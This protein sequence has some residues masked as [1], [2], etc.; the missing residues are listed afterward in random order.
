[1]RGQPRCRPGGVAE[2]A[3]PLGHR[4]RQAKLA[5][6][7]SKLPDAAG[8]ARRRTG[9]G[10]AHDGA[11]ARTQF[12][13]V[14]RIRQGPQA[15]RGA[16]TASIPAIRR[17]P[18][19][20]E[21]SPIPSAVTPKPNATFR[22]RSGSDPRNAEVL[23]RSGLLLLPAGTAL[24]GRKRSGQGHAAGAANKRYRN[25]L[26][27]VLGHLGR[28]E[29]ALAHFRQANPEADA[30]YNLAFIF[31]AQERVE[32]PR[33]ASRW[34]SMPIRR[35]ARPA[36]HWL[37]S[38]NTKSFPSTCAISI[39]S[40]TDGV[41]WVPFVEGVSDEAERRASRRRDRHQSRRQPRHP[42][43]APGVAG[44]AEPQHAEPA[45]RRAGYRRRE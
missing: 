29:E 17:S 19:A 14:R 34:R 1:M 41:R 32:E 12:R 7:A 42:R 21:S 9:P 44:H 38:R 39:R 4:S 28:H 5:Q 16:A 45:K 15:L 8:R 6:S 2:I 37:R 36:K 33:S 25:N 13:A 43:P 35:T 26:G 3:V 31:A 20:W 18:I 23:G 30:Y 27:L 11:A 40:P 10:A 24:Q 22:P